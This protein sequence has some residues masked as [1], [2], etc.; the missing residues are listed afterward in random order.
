MQWFDPE[1]DPLKALEIM[2]KNQVIFNDLL[3]KQ[4]NQ[5]Q[6]LTQRLL[7]QEKITDELL[8]AVE[9]SNKSNEIL[10]NSFSQQMQSALEKING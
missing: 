10:L 3:Q 7:H 1:F 8:K 4:H 9:M 2:Q 6:Q 5:I